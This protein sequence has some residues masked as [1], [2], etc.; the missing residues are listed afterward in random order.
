M[1]K[2]NCRLYA[3]WLTTIREE[4]TRMPKLL[5]QVLVFLVIAFVVYYLITRPKDAA[6]F[7]LSMFDAFES[8]VI[9]FATLAQGI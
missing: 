8:I 4:V 9:F 5:K 6:A 1:Y 2:Y 3:K 7:V